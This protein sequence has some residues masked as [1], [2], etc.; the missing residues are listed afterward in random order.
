MKNEFKVYRCPICGKMV[1][2]IVETAVTPHCCGQPMQLLPANS[3]EGIGEKHVPVTRLEN[4]VLDVKVGEVPH[5]SSE[6]HHI[7]WIAVKGKE[8]VF[9]RFLKAGDE[10]ALR[11]NAEGF[12]PCRVFAHCNLHGLW[13][14]GVELT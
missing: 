9:F 14:G 4:G 13:K 3:F 5:P 7:E 8:G 12:S 2:E 1:W 6:V 11:M 10:P